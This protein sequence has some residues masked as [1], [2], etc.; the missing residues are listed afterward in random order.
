MSE[1]RLE[2]AFVAGLGCSVR[3]YDWLFGQDDSEKL[4]ETVCD[5]IAHLLLIPDDALR[6]VVGSG[7]VGAR[8]VVELSS[9]SLASRPVCAIALSS[10][11]PS[12]GAIVVID[13]RDGVVRYSSVRPDPDLGWPAA[14]PWVGHRLPA[15]HPLAGLQPGDRMTRKTFWVAPWGTR[16]DY[17]VDAVVDGGHIVAV[18]SDR[19]LWGCE[20]LHLDG[21]RQFVQRPE[22]TILCCGERRQARGFPCSTCG[23]FFC[24]EC[25]RCDCDRRNARAETCS[26]CGLEKQKHLLDGAGVCVDCV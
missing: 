9:T 20:R 14:V 17:Y 19:D 21:P 25:S 11:L 26:K 8:H 18:F 12:T 16:E 23:A 4:L 22:G 7:P 13:R 10:A 5:C 24:P 1:V 6:S 3:I 15:G 2:S